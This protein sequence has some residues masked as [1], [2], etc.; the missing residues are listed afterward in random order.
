MGVLSDGYKEE[1][2]RCNK[3]KIRIITI[4]RT[5]EEEEKEWKTT[6]LFLNM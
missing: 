4:K 3:I 5:Q 6:R 1:R 2:S